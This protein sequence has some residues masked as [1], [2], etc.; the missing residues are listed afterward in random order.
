MFVINCVPEMYQQVMHQVLQNYEGVHHIMD[1][2]IIHGAPKDEHDARLKC[3][4][5]KIRECA[6]VLNRDKCV[7]NLC[8]NLYLWVMFCLLKV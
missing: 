5:D 1:D 6:L 8:L 3:V 7:F 2:I 4:L